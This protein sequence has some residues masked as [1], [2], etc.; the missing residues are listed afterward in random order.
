MLDRI[1]LIRRIHQKVIAQENALVAGVM[2]YTQED[3]SDEANQLHALDHID[4]VDFDG[5]ENQID[6]DAVSPAMRE[7][8]A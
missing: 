8:F 6:M 4:E 2:D 1:E 5:D 7:I 3:V